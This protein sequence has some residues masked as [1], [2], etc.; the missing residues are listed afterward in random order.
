MSD[1]LKPEDRRRAM[2]A[3]RGKGTKV[4]KRFSSILVRMGVR[5]WRKNAD[6]VIGKPDI[7]FEQQRIAIFIDGC[8]WHGC[9]SCQR[10]MPRTNRAYWERKINRNIVIARSNNRQ[11]RGRG[12]TVIRVWEHEVNNNS[13]TEKIKTKILHTL[14]IK[15]NNLG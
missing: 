3:V 9:P 10:K 4:E 6:N 15:E 11:L 14:V 8:F 5:G 1:N 2:Q 7:V 13:G 12:W